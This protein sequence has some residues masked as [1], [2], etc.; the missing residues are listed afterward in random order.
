MTGWRTF[1]GSQCREGARTIPD[2]T[3]QRVAC[4]KDLLSEYEALS[5]GPAVVDRSYRGLLEVSGADRATWLHNLTT[6]EVKNLQRGEGNHAFAVTLKGRIL[7]DLN[8]LVR[9]EVIWVDLDRRYLDR[10]KA[11]FD[12]YTITEDVKVID[13]SEE[14]GR[15]GLVG[16][17]TVR[18][19]EELGA[20]QARAMASL[21]TAGITWRGLELSL[22]RH[23]FC[24]PFG[25]ELFVPDDKAVEFWQE[26]V[27][28]SRT[29]P[30][31]PAGDDAVQVHRIEAGLLWPGH[32]VC[33]DVLPAETGLLERAV[34]FQKGCYLGQEVVERMRSRGALARR[35]CGLRIKGDSVPPEDA[36]LLGKDGKPVG[37]LTS[38]C[39]SIALSGVI[40]MG[41]VKTESGQDGASLR[42]RWGDGQAVEAVIAPLPF[43]AAS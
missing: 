40:G 41:Y 19:L 12:K 24:G 6:N 43:V 33:D 9:E 11:H 10:A 30:A 32:E 29:L 4:Y 21:G 31:I 5:G 35:L 28:P 26:L 23:D 20:P 37:R 22:V 15:F 8:V 38:V 2:D 36:A 17:E 39:R 1:V 3:N 14:F 16:C 42:V 18:L 27:D 7:F 25:V 34:S 13:R